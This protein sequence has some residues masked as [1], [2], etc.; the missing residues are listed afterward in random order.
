MSIGSE[1]YGSFMSPDGVLH[2]GVTNIDI[3]DLT[4]DADSRPVG[5]DSHPADFNG[6]R[7][8]SDESRGGL[9]DNIKYSD[10]CMRDMVNGVLVSTAYNPLFA[11]ASY[12]DFRNLEFHNVRAVSCGGLQPAVV[13]LEGYNAT[14]RPT[15]TLDNFIF[16]NLNPQ[17]GVAA[18]FATFNLGP[19]PVNFPVQGRGVDVVDMRDGS[20][21]P[22]QCNFTTLPAPQPPPGWKN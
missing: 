12:P 1:T 5:I 3:W 4:I 11:G 6:I 17:A 7:V 2:K 10:V 16:D 20:S 18:E 21:M 8:K 22:K 19:G 9:V 14:L 15:I 13:T